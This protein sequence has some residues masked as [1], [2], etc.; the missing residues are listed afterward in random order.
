MADAPGFIHHTEVEGTFYPHTSLPHNNAMPDAVPARKMYSSVSVG[1][2]QYTE[3]NRGVGMQDVKALA[4]ARKVSTL[5][6]VV[7]NTPRP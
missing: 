6:R 4:K 7:P 2:E 3:D 1:N 5:R